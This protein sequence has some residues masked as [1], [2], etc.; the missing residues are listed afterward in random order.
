M[1]DTFTIHAAKTHLSQLIARVE[2]GEEIIIARGDKPVARLAP[3]A[4]AKPKRE[5]GS[6]AGL[7]GKLGPEFFDP[8]PQAELD[9]W[10]GKLTDA[11]GV[12]LPEE[13]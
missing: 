3:L 2:A 13:K 9:A 12:S 5:F 1:S 11:I 8:L 4:P 6:M 7:V 10:E